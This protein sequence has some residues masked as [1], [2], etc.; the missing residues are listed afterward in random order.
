[1]QSEGKEVLLDIGP[2]WPA[3]FPARRTVTRISTRIPLSNM[4]FVSFRK[5]VFLGIR[6]AQSL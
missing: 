6:N 5:A 3:M 2:H 1:M 4:P